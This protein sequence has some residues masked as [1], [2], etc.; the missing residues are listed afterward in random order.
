MLD[1]ATFGEPTVLTEADSTAGKMS[2]QTS[3]R[4]EICKRKMRLT[5]TRLLDLLVEKVDG[6]FVRLHSEPVHKAP[7]Q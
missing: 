6:F 2:K 4:A 7:I 1:Y 3:N 5:R